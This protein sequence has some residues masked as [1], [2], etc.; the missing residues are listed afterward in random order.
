[1]TLSMCIKWLK[2]IKNMM[3]PGSDPDKALD[4]AID[5][6]EKTFVN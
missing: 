1:M 6:L 5:Y 2:W 3:I 4:M